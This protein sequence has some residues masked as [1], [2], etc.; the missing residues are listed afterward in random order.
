MLAETLLDQPPNDASGTTI[1]LFVRLR[2]TQRLHGS[3]DGMQLDRFQSGLVYDVGSILGAVLLAEQWAE[4]VDDD[5]TSTVTPVTN[6]GQFA[7]NGGRSHSKRRRHATRG[8]HGIA[9]DRAARRR[10][11]REERQGRR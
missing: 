4:P 8:D 5:Y 11:K 10:S 3:I 6:V 9:A 1:R 2:I 7:E